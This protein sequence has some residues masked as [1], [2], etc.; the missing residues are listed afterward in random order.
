M[1]IEATRA[2]LLVVLN[3]RLVI[4]LP[5]SLPLLS[6]SRSTN[7]TYGNRSV[8]AVLKSGA[9]SCIIFHLSSSP[10]LTL[11]APG[12]LSASVFRPAS[13][14]AC[15]HYL[16]LYG[17]DEC[18]CL[19]RLGVCSQASVASREEPEPQR[20]L[21]QEGQNPLFLDRQS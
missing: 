12:R 13:R 7:G 15:L 14:P 1:Y 4:S 10:Y 6:T 2:A 19:N 9:V 20:P 21:P 8:M 18:A 3:Y 16:F 5:F 11:R 17:D